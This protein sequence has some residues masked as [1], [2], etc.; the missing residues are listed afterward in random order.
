MALLTLTLL[1]GGAI[2]GGS[3]LPQNCLSRLAHKSSFYSIILDHKSLSP[4]ITLSTENVMAMIVINELG[5]MAR[6]I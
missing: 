3:K 6:Y 1:I 5:E 2:L 4:D